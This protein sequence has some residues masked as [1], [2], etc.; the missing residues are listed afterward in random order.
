MSMGTV[1]PHTDIRP[2]PLA[3][4]WYPSN[5]D[6]LRTSINTFLDARPA[7]TI[8][9]KILGLVVP[10]AGH[11]YSGQTAALAFKLLDGMQLSYAAVISPSHRLGPGELLTSGHDAY[12]TPLGTIPVSAGKINSL[13][14]VLQ[15]N[16]NLNLTKIRY[17][18]EH[19]LEIELPFLQTVLKAPFKLIPVMMAD[20]SIETARAL[21]YSLAS[22][23]KN[24][25]AVLIASTDLSHF[26]S[27]DLAL[28]F[29]TEMLSRFEAFDPEGVIQAEEEQFGF[30]CG[31]GAVAAV[32]WACQQLGA[33][34]V[35]VLGYSTSGD[36]TG[37]YSSV[38]GYGSAVIYRQD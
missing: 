6:Q 27:R 24:D 35:Q 17:D 30:A 23:V 29:D 4:S 8:P 1:K 3:G 2:S 7:H 18:Q 36:V 12:S 26:Y 37:D 14:N 16:Y 19:S 11:Q 33:D 38:V 28:R 15:N 10:H 25:S 20:Q 31:R 21:G 22:T 5:P 13:D 9:G 34:T 32:L